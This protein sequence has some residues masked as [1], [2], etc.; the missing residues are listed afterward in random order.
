MDPIKVPIDVL[1]NFYVTLPMALIMYHN[2][3][4]LYAQLFNKHQ[5]QVCRLRRLIAQV[6]V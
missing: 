5:K 6:A 4:P 2:V 1:W 3:D